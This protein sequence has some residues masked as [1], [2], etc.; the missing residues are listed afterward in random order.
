MAF[1]RNSLAGLALIL[2]ITLSVIIGVAIAS[3]LPRMT[4]E[5]GGG[6]GGEL[7]I[8][9]I[10]NNLN[11]GYNSSSPVARAARRAAESQAVAQVSDETLR[12]VAAAITAKARD[13]DVNAA[14]FVFEL[15]DA[16]KK[17]RA[18]AAAKNAPTRTGEGK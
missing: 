12:D 5:G 4:R 8:S 2:A 9:G 17:L 7:S 14:A 1:L 13:G 16:Q 15:A 10:G 11:G 18:E 3:F 6:G